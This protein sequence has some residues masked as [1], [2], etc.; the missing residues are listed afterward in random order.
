MNFVTDLEQIIV[1]DT[2]NVDSRVR[3]GHLNLRVTDLDRATTFYCDVLGLTISYYGPAIGLPTVF[4]AFDDYRHDVVLNWVYGDSAKA[5]PVGHGGLNHFAIRYPDEL[6][7]ANAV[8]RLQ[9]FDDLIEDARDHGGTVSFYLRDPEG[10]G[11]EL[12][13]DRPR[14]HW[15]DSFDQLI[16]KSETFNI[17]RWLK[18]AFDRDAEASVQPVRCQLQEAL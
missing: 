11:V 13:Y 1:A 8:S 4:L 6:S 3:I 14:S 2:R 17:K 15:F 5:K 12:Y 10:N 7:L 16:I 18:D 9:Q